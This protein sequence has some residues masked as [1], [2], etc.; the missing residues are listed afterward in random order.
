MKFTF[1]VILTLTY[2][3]TTYIL[4]KKDILNNKSVSSDVKSYHNFFLNFGLKQLIK[5]AT[6][7]TCSISTI[8]DHIL[9]SLHERA[10]QSGVIDIGLSN[11]QLIYCTRKISSKEIILHG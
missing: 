11:H 8:V 1:L 6:R 10:I 9:A 2:I 4:A 3:S 7:V 5:V